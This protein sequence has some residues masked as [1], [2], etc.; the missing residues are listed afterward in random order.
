MNSLPTLLTERTIMMIPAPEQAP[1]L[2]AY[3]S[4]NRAHLAPWEPARSQDYFTEASASRWLEESI[5][6]ARAGS[7]LRFVA[8]DRTSG[9]AVATCSFTNIVRG[10]FLACHLGFSVAASRQ[11]TGL[12][13]E[14]TQAG[15]AHMF[16]QE[17]LHRIMANHLPHNVRSEKLLRELGFEREGY[18]RSYLCID[19]RWED[20]VLN[21]LVNAA[22]PAKPAN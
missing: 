3:R 22:G 12:M 6:L 13:R 10:I 7:G 18:A 8:F 2:Q 19:G 20:M 21:S 15:I 17:G 4:N 11:G 9:E 5:A 16:D 1:L 14:V